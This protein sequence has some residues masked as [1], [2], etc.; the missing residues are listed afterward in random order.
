[1][2]AAVFGGGPHRVGDQVEQQV[3]QQVGVAPQ[4]AGGLRRADGQRQ[5]V[6]GQGAAQRRQQCGK[7]HRPQRH[8]A[9]GDLH[10][11]QQLAAE[12]F[13]PAGLVGDVAGGALPQFGVGALGAQQLGVAQDAG[14]GGFQLVAQRRDKIL[15]LAHGQGAAVQLG[16]QG[17][18]HMV[19]AAAEG[20]DLVAA[21]QRGAAGVVAGGDLPAGR[22]QRPQRPGQAV[23]HKPDRQPRRRKH[24]QLDPEIAGQQHGL[25]VVGGVHRVSA[26]I[27]DGG[28]PHRDA[29]GDQVPAAAVRGGAQHAAVG[30]QQCQ[31]P[32]QLHLLRHGR[33]GQHPAVREQRKGPLAAGIAVHGRAVLRQ[34]E[35]RVDVGGQQLGLQGAAFPQLLGLGLALH[36]GQRGG[37][38][39]PDQQPPAQRQHQPQHRQHRQQQFL[40][41][42]H[43]APSSIYPM[44]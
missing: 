9:A 41:K 44:R 42:L 2:D 31:L 43:G 40:R 17:V 12:R 38:V 15:P 10:Q 24:R 33:V 36:G 16:L 29:V 22:V 35:H 5:A 13:Q 3:A 26:H 34:V 27:V 7:R 30:V 28:L 18:G 25:G 39:L 4:R 20:R 21:G 8:G 14:H 19:K 11:I 37:K 6:L 1:M 32:G 23:D